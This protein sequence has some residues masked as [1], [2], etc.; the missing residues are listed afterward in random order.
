VT[1]ASSDLAST[2]PVTSRGAGEEVSVHISRDEAQAM[3]EPLILELSVKISRLVDL[4]KATSND[5]AQNSD[6]RAAIAWIQRSLEDVE[7]T[8]SAVNRRRC[9]AFQGQNLVLPE[10]RFPSSAG[11][12]SRIDQSSC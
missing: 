4:L 10:T 2:V 12:T 7:A 9:A 3:I 8:I 6:D 11:P 5:P 1:A